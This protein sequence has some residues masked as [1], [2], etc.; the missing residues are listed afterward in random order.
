M[1]IF[2]IEIGKRRVREQYTD[3]A[4][5]FVSRW[6]RPPTLNTAE[7]LNMFSKSPRLAVVDRIASDTANIGGKLLRVEP[8]GTETEI[9][10]HPFLR[11]MDQPNPLYEM[12]GSPS[13]GCTKSTFCW[14]G[15]SFLLIERE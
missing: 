12:T 15:E 13:G 2:N 4:G 14:M 1:R 10:S 3:K 6:S 5:S 11:F 8:D 9:T 7:W